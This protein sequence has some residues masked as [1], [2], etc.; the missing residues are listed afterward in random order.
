[1]ITDV[2]KGNTDRAAPNPNR[3]DLLLT[4][5]VMAKGTNSVNYITPATNLADTA[6][7]KNG[8]FTIVQVGTTTTTST[9]TTTNPG[10]GQYANDQFT[11]YQQPHGLGFLPAFIAY[12]QSQAGQ[13]TAIPFTRYVT[14]SGTQA[15]WY[16]FYVVVDAT[17]VYVLLDTMT[18]GNVSVAFSPGFIFKWYLMFQTSN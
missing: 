9:Y 3:H 11:V 6:A 4:D 16:T 13:Y 8:Q 15:A 5:S 1:M 18:Y 10:A 17:Y 2:D 14:L 12:E 7:A